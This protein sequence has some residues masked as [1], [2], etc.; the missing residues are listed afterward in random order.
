MILG[1]GWKVTAMIAI[2]FEILSLMTTMHLVGLMPDDDYQREKDRLVRDI[3][4]WG[5]PVVQRDKKA[6]E[7]DRSYAKGQER[8]DGRCEFLMGATRSSEFDWKG[9]VADLLEVA[10]YSQSYP[11][12]REVIETEAAHLGVEVSDPLGF[13]GTAQALLEIRNL[14]RTLMSDAGNPY[15]SIWKL[16]DDIRELRDELGSLRASLSQPTRGPNIEQSRRENINEIE[17]LQKDL[18]RLLTAAALSE[19]KGDAYWAGSHRGE[20]AKIESKLRALGA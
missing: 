3:Q 12:E 18:Q 8:E 19:A 4:S 5:N 2:K 17:S 16:E 20:A 11:F 13:S 14:R 7:A 10:F 15:T 1:F 9:A 6:W